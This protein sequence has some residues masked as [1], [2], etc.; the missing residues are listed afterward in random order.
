MVL[1][2]KTKYIFIRLLQFFDDHG[3]ISDLH[4]TT[5]AVAFNAVILRRLLLLVI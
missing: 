2:D 3:H 1:I 4:D 5:A